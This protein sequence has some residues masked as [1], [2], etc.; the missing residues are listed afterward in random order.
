[1]INHYKYVKIQILHFFWRVPYCV[2]YPYA[3]RVSVARTRKH[4]S[5]RILASYAAI[6]CKNHVQKSSDRK[7]SFIV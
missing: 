7:I 3:L 4:M 5:I 1:M 2:S 6:K